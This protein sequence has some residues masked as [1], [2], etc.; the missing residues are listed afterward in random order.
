MS[1][2]DT[3]RGTRRWCSRGATCGQ[4]YCDRTP[5]SQCVHEYDE[6]AC[7]PEMRYPGTDWPPP[8]RWTSLSGVVVYRSY[9]DYVDD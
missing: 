7:P 6:A 9:A 8:R 2:A 1:D 3:K 5:V 4:G